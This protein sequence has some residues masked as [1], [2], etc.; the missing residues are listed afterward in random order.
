MQKIPLSLA[1]PAM[2]LARD[3]R[4]IDDDPSSPPVCGKGI[5]LTEALIARLDRMGIQAV[6]VEGHPIKI[7]GENTTGDMLKALEIRFS[8]VAGDPLMDKLK[9]L[10]RQHIIESMGEED[11]G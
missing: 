4:K 6:F 11:A 2:V 5:A 10:Y 3:V 1:A 7:E 9:E 8:K